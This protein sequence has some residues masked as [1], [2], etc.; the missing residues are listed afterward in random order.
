MQ[1]RD[2]TEIKHYMYRALW[3][4]FSV[5]NKGHPIAVIKKKAA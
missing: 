5:F 3:G 2:R 1:W 4:P